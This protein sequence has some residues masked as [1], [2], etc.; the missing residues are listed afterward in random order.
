MSCETNVPD[1]GA[2]DELRED[3]DKHEKEDS[4]QPGVGIEKT[5]V[6]P[7]TFVRTLDFQVD[8]VI[9]FIALQ[10]NNRRIFISAAMVLHQDRPTSFSLIICK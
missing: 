7:P 10:E 6:I 1:N 5:S 8:R 9:N 4:V 2:S 3:T